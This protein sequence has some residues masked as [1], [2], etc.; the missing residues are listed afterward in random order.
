MAPSGSSKGPIVE[1]LDL[2]FQYPM[3]ARALNGVNLKVYPGEFVAIVG[4]NG[5][6]KTT[7]TR[8]LNGLL[9]PQAGDIRL[10]GKS[11]L[12]E[13]TTKLCSKV[14]YVFKTRMSSFSALLSRMN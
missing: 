7:L 4:Q 11:I 10:F 5:A 2:E 1:V 14:G 3:G 6:G 9:R 13:P 12:N 8:H